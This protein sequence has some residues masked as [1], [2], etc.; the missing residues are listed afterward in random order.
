MKPPELGAPTGYPQLVSVQQLPDYGDICE[1]PADR[2]SLTVLQEEANLFGA[3][4]GNSVYAASQDGGTTVDVTRQPVRTIRDTYPIYS[5]VAVDPN[6]DEVILQDNNLWA[7]AVFRRTDNTSPNGPPTEPQ[8]L[9]KGL[10]TE[11]QFNNGLY[12]D[13]KIGEIYSIESD[14]GDKIVMFSHDALGNVAPVRTLHTPHRGYGI[15]VDEEKQELYVT[16]EYPPKVMVYRKG[17]SGEEK[18]LRFLEG[19]HTQLQAIHGVAVDPKNKVLFVNNWGN[20]SNFKVPGTGKFHPPS[21]TVYPLGAS[22]DVAPVRVIQGPKTQMNWPAAMSINPDNGDLYV[23]NDVGQ[24]ILV[25]KATDQGDVAPTRVI[26]GN[27]TGLVNPT[28]V[29]IDL[30]NREVWVANLGNSTATAYPLMASGD[31]APVRTIRSAPVGYK[32]TKFGKTEA[33]AFDSKRQEYLVPN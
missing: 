19:E 12:V 31:V 33:V 5:S 15:A 9:I 26:R 8:R 1:W 23:A 6:F 22:G 10:N 4:R 18:P 2:S 17:A 20:E 29:S 25:F 28:G 7:T 27:K 16:V 24:S 14:T 3:L 21:I 11:I 30:K 32:S 13:P